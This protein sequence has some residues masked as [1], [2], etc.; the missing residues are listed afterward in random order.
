MVVSKNSIWSGGRAAVAAKEGEG[1]KG[2][3]VA[4]RRAVRGGDFWPQKGAK[5][6]SAKDD[7][8]ALLGARGVEGVE[9]GGLNAEITGERGVPRG[10][11]KTRAD[12]SLA[13]AATD[14][15]RGFMR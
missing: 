15:G 9:G 12:L 1:V 4:R 7:R 10:E 8:K 13:L 3:M 14:A 6:R 5:N 11:S 2:A